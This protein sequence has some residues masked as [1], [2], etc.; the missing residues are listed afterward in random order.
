MGLGSGRLSHTWSMT[1]DHVCAECGLDYRR[2][3]PS[4]AR[5]AIRSY[6]RRYRSALAAALEDDAEEGIIRR[7]PDAGTWSALEYAA[8]VADRFDQFGDVISRMF[9]ETSPT[10]DFCDA[11]ERAVLQRYNDQDPDVVLDH[12]DEA[13]SRLSAAVERVDSGSWDRTATF[14]FGERDLLTMVRTAVHE[15][16]HHLRDV[17][18]VLAVARGR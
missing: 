17:Q 11:D 16:S 3:S 2:V 10:I 9:S 4:D 6:P 15:G 13:A 1:S 5:V 8:H 18:R 14:P 7:R 12:L